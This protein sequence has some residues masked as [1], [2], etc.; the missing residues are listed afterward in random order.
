MGRV[1]Q[2]EIFKGKKAKIFVATVLLA[3]ILII[4]S[5]IIGSATGTAY[6]VSPGESLQEAINAAKPG[7]T[8][9]VASG[10][11]SGPISVTKRLILLGIDTGSGKP[12]IDAG[13]KGSA[14]NLL[15]EGSVLEGFMVRN[16]GGSELEAGIKVSSRNMTVR[17]NTV[18]DNSIGIRLQ[19]CKSSVIE[20][21]ELLMIGIFLISLEDNTDDTIWDSHGNTVETKFAN[22]KNGTTVSSS[23]NYIVGN[24]SSNSQVT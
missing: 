20:D 2:N 21:N 23:G 6:Q 1:R 5:T 18:V 16:S 10:T 4:G 8:I 13:G 17:K 12:V 14:I 7:N 3:G 22:K 19:F 15:V 24:S 11:Y 9:E